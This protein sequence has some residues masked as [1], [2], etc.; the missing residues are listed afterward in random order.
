MMTMS[1]DVVIPDEATYV[2]QDR[3]GAWCAYSHEPDNK[4]GTQGWDISD[5]SHDYWDLCFSEPPKDW[6]QEIYRIIR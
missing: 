4:T 1:F 5:T 6:A 3:N 2:A